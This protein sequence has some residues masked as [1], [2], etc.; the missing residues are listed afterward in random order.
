MAGAGGASPTDAGAGTDAGACTC[1]VHGS[2]SLD[3][4]APCLLTIAV[5]GG[6]ERGA[7]STVESGGR[8]T[9]PSDK[10]TVPAD[11]WS[12]D[13]LTADCAGHYTL[14]YTLKAGMASN[15]QPTDCVLAQSC[16]EADYATLNQAQTWPAL[17]GWLATSTQS[18]CAAAFADSGGYGVKTVTGTPAGCPS[19]SKVIGT[20]SYC[21]TNC[22]SSNPSPNCT[23]CAD[24]TSGF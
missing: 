2:W 13:T 24:G 5:D 8:A 6:H 14:C 20:V 19:I 18:A 9:C 1:F 23:T 4:T 21:P 12:T 17:P 15:P 10:S 7:I 11:P 3:N 22:T 16:A